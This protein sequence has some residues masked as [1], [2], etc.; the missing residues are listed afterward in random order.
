MPTDKLFPAFVKIDYHSAFGAHVMTLC[1]RELA[2]TGIGDP[3][4]YEAWDFSTI[5]ADVMIENFID[6][7]AAAIPAAM[8]VDAYTIYKVPTIGAP[9]QP[10]YTSPYV[11]VGSAA[12]L[13]GQAKAVQ[14]TI[15]F[16]TELFGDAR[17]VVLDRPVNGSFGSFTDPGAEF[18]AL[19]AEF[20][21]ATNA[22]AGRDNARPAALTNA[23]IT[24]NKRL[25]RKYDM[26]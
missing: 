19:G 16:K 5:A 20:M 17:I 8:T 9:P 22:W 23:S 25:R 12:G 13:T 11:T 18:A 1:T 6:L 26:I 24:L 3:G 21:A 7:F 2:T 10:V 15:G 14:V 4:S